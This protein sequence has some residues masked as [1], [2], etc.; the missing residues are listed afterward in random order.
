VSTTEQGGQ[1]QLERPVPIGR[2]DALLLAGL[3]DRLPIVVALNLGVA[4]GTM[5]VFAGRQS[6]LIL[7]GWFLLMVLTLGLRLYSW[8]AF[9]RAPADAARAPVWARR[10]TLGAAATG[11]AW[12]LAGV[13]LYSPHSWQAQVFLPFIMA[14][15]VGG[16]VTALTGHMPA[17]LAFS[18]CMLVPY[19]LRLVAEADLPHLVMAGLVVLYLIGMGVLGRTVSASLVASVRLALENQD[20]VAALRDKSAQLEATFDHIHQGVAVFDRDGRLATWNPR[21]RELHGYPPDLYRRG[22]HFSGFLRHD[23]TR[24]GQSGPGGEDRLRRTV[25]HPAPAR[26]EQPGAGHRI[27]EVERSAMPGGGFVSTSTDITERKRAEARMLH[28]AQHD[29]LTGLPNRLLF[30][31]RLRQAMARSRRDRT[32]LAVALV[33]LDRFKAVNDAFGHRIGDGVLKQVG[34]RLRAALRESDTVA[35]IGGDEFALI[36]PDLPDADAA[37]LIA[38]KVSAELDRPFGLDIRAWQ[39]GASLGLALFPSDGESAEHLVQNADLAMYRA[40]AAGGGWQRFGSTI[41]RDFDHL[42]NLKHEL[43]RAIAQGQLSLEYQPQLDLDPERVSGIEA[44]LRWQHPEFGPINPETLIKVAEDSG[45]IV[46]IGEWALAEAC[47][48]AAGWPSDP[49]PIRV[50]VNVSASQL[51]QPDL[52]AQVARIL[53]ASGLPAGRLE[54]ELTESSVLHEVERIQTTLE[55]LHALGVVLALDDFGTGYASLSH[56]KRFPLDVLKIDR[57]FVADLAETADAA[58]VRSLIELGHRL[59][60]RVVAEGVETEQQLVALR[61][62]GCDAIQGHVVGH[63]LGAEEIGPWLR[64]RVWVPG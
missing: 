20:L 46:A 30:Q 49:L 12:G 7:G 56:L 60:L 63:P 45:Q 55:A 42:Q 25:R 15:M 28:L 18:V 22:A 32:L 64:A 13:L 43:A 40:K 44:L 23:L 29:P 47:R 10:F 33:D 9:R 48:V 54:L 57:S 24:L 61:R 35:R 1:S 31:D 36:L 58:I 53:D 37:N 62:L 52:L 4:L 16:S 26:F 38:E 17:Y 51:A 39:P 41:K 50:A 8:R 19:A 5:I 14:G 34:A 6:W 27:L 21:H 59:E 3:F 2:A 11:A